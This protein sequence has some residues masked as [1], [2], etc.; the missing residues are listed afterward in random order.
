MTVKRLRELATLVD[1]EVA[2]DGETEIEGVAPLEDA[3]PG[4]ISF[5]ANP[6]YRYLLTETKASAVIVPME[7]ETHP[8]ISLLRVANPY[9]AFARVVDLFKPAPGY[10]R[11]IH[12]RGEVHEGAELGHD[13]SLY[14]FAVVDEGAHIGDRVVL[15]PGV[16]I[17]RNAVIGDDTLLYPNVTVREGCRIGRR[18]IVHAN[19]VIGSDGFG[20]AREGNAYHKIPQIGIVVVEDDVEIGACVTVDRATLGATVIRR[21]TKVDNIVQIAHN[22]EVGEDSIIV[23]QVG[24]SGSTK[25]GN[26]VTLAGQVGI[27][28]HVEIGDDITVGAQ[29]GVI[30]N[31]PEKGVFTG[32]PAV[33]H[34]Q[35]LRIQ[36]TLTKLPEMRKRLL[37]LEERIEEMEKKRGVPKSG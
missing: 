23:A 9:L 33:P 24:I 1:G 29:S 19:S 4:D 11:G 12:P 14:P 3:A 8:G 25:I 7:E 37:K 17:G 27:V 18:V 2:G 16:Y 32:S 6:K 13:V 35:W 26:R 10:Y 34:S 20:Y 5:I 15:F 36:G 28:G 31:L 22:V 21:G 30:G